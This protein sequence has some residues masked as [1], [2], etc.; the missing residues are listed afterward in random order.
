MTDLVVN[1]P[2]L[3]V[4]VAYA[5]PGTVRAEFA[6]SLFSLLARYQ[7]QSRI[8]LGSGPRIAT[9]RNKIIRS[10]LDRTSAQWLWMVDADMTFTPDILERMLDCDQQVVGALCFARNDDGTVYPTLYRDNRPD[11]F[12]D[13]VFDYEPDSLMEVDATGAAC[14][15]VHREVLEK[16]GL[17][18]D[19]PYRWFADEAED[20]REIGEDITFCLRVRKLGYPVYVHTGIVC[21]HVK[22]KIVT[23]QDYLGG[24]DVER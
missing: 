16:V 14:L 22:T 8:C 13:R 18:N 2:L 7:L 4:C 10:F 5:H 9:T 11:G 3:D 23:E 19:E 15:L 21:G 12:I 24:P 6:D 17:D 1:K 20:G